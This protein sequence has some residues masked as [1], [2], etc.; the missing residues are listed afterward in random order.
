MCCNLS[1]SH[2]IHHF[3]ASIG[4]VSTGVP[5]RTTGVAVFIH[6]DSTAVHAEARQ[7][8]Q[9]VSQLCLS[10][11][12][13]NQVGLQREL[14]SSYW[15]LVGI[16]AHALNVL[17]MTGAGACGYYGLPLRGSALTECSRPFVG[18]STHVVFHASVHHGD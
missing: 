15:A 10:D 6:H 17:H 9:H 7:H 13:E 8:R 4:A 16:N 14:C 2:R 1:F 5:T 11:G 12:H 18:I 3:L